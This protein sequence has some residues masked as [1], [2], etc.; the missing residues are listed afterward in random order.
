MNKA[1]E[2][3]NTLINAATL[4]RDTAVFNVLLPR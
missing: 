2:D 3:G 1:D 4:N